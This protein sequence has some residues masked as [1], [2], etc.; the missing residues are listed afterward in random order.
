F[1]L[2]YQPLKHPSRILVRT[3]MQCWNRKRIYPFKVIPMPDT[4]LHTRRTLPAGF[5]FT[6]QPPTSQLVPDRKAQNRFSRQIAW[7]NPIISR[8]ST[9]YRHA[10]P[11]TKNSVCAPRPRPVSFVFANP[12]ADRP[13]AIPHFLATTRGASDMIGAQAKRNQETLL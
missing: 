9:T 2:Q 8:Q 13:I 11:H 12:P 3:V 1:S 4:R 10:P 6:L 7:G 5:V